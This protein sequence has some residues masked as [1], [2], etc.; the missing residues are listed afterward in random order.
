MCKKNKDMTSDSPS[1]DNKENLDNQRKDTE[2][3]EKA[4]LQNSSDHSVCAKNSTSAACDAG[5]K[6]I[7]DVNNTIAG[8]NLPKAY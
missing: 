7:I 5:K 8:D 3:Q 2:D 6:K 1:S 4:A